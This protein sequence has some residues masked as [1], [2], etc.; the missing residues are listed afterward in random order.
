MYQLRMVSRKEEE[1][2]DIQTQSNGLMLKKTDLTTIFS[3]L[4]GAQ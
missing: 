4:C 2:S 3:G 1:G